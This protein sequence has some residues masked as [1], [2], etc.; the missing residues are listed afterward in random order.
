MSVPKNSEANLPYTF[1]GIQRSPRLKSSSAKGMG[2][3]VAARRAARLS[4]ASSWS[5]WSKSHDSI[6]SAFSIT[7]PEINLSATS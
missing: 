7:L 1:E 2:V 4:L 6:R 3:G 5:G